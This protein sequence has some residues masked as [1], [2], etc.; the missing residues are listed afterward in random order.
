MGSGARKYIILGLIFVLALAITGLVTGAIGAGLIQS[1]EQKATGET[2]EGPF[3]PKPEVHLPA[4]VTC[5]PPDRTHYRN[6]LLP[7]RAQ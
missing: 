2:A 4:P 7:E 1:E 3:I 5:P 6:L